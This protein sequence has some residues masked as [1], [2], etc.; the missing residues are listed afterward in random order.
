MD[1]ENLL[2]SLS[3]L[4]ENTK[5][6]QS[7]VTKIQNDVSI[8]KSGGVSVSS[9]GGVTMA[10]TFNSS[11]T[12]QAVSGKLVNDHL[13]TKNYVP[14]TAGRTDGDV[15]TINNNMASW[16]TPKSNEYFLA[17][18][19]ATS[20]T[21]S[22]DTEVLSNFTV[23][24]RSSDL[25]FSN[26]NQVFTAPRTGVYRIKFDT[27][28]LH[29]NVTNTLRNSELQIGI[30]YP[31]SING[32][33]QLYSNIFPNTNS[34]ASY[35]FRKAAVSNVIAPYRLVYS[36]IVSADRS[37]DFRHASTIGTT[38]PYPFEFANSPITH[39]QNSNTDIE[40]ILDSGSVPTFN[41]YDGYPG[42][43]VHRIN[44][45]DTDNI[46]M[47][48]GTTE[49]FS[50][51][52]YVK[53]GASVSSSI[54]AA[55]FGTRETAGS[56][57][58]LFAILVYNSAN[59]SLIQFQGTSDTDGY[60]PIEFSN[61]SQNPCALST[62]E[63]SH[64]VV[65]YSVQ[66]TPPFNGTLK[67]FLNGVLQRQAVSTIGSNTSSFLSGRK[68]KV[69]TPGEVF[70]GH[71]HGEDD[72]GFEELRFFRYYNTAL[73]AAQV[74]QLNVA[75][76]H[77][78]F[79]RTINFPEESAELEESNSVNL[80]GTNS[81]NFPSGSATSG[82]TGNSTSW[83]QLN[84]QDLSIPANGFTIEWYGVIGNQASGNG[85]FDMWDT[86]TTTLKPTPHLSGTGARNR[87]ALWNSGDFNHD[88]LM[89]YFENGTQDNGVNNRLHKYSISKT[90]EVHLV[91]VFS[92]TQEPI[93]YV[94]GDEEIPSSKDYTAI[95]YPSVG[96]RDY[97]TIG[98]RPDHADA[99]LEQIRAFR[100]YPG[101][102][103]DAAVKVLYKTSVNAF[104]DTHVQGTGNPQSVTSG[105]QFLNIEKLL[106]LSK[107]DKLGFAQKT[108]SGNHGTKASVMIHS[109]D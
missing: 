77:G 45:T 99:G 34:L 73:S 71:G 79:Y 23:L 19:N 104:V 47:T 12:T 66:T 40:L 55:I 102:F 94:D 90:A 37:Y 83:L 106:T 32:Q 29:A 100:M 62:T 14:G 7:D 53:P 1:E 72:R 58:I 25:M 39:A 84:P 22:S 76:S 28:M 6:I 85:L 17:T 9:S 57:D 3:L 59:G 105:S 97:V 33:T 44:F 86:D 30:P 89:L 92:S 80:Y 5:M 87:I 38:S 88:N 81:S 21:F 91:V 18:R 46:P 54:H 51:E 2:L 108:D 70:L 93:L 26:T 98:R 96:T 67:V 68:L 16:V 27:E 48:G 41:T 56:S 50:L 31:L 69:V 24:Q 13:D 36:N 75:H 20:D 61:G 35:D 103:D 78:P 74:A 42:S 107:D 52:F 82:M 11:N 15:L 10:S 8:L 4:T 109:V 49:D 43:N 101:V 64:L 63:F 60:G 65:T 95:T